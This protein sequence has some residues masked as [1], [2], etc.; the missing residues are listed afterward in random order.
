MT[1]G[2]YLTSINS[3]NENDM[4]ASLIRDAS[5]S[6]IGGGNAWIGLNYDRYTQSKKWVNGNPITYSKTPD[7]TG[8]NLCCIVIADRGTWRY[9]PCSGS[10]N[11]NR[12]YFCRRPGGKFNIFDIIINCQ[13]YYYLFIY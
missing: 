8:S 2:G 13:S 3:E 11:N 7:S 1:R 9:F 6:G 10:D 4:L 5:S 12:E